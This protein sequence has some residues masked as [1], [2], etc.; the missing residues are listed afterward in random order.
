MEDRG[1]GLKGTACASECPIGDGSDIEG[2]SRSTHGGERIGHF[3]R[4][5]LNRDYVRPSRSSNAAKDEKG[6]EHEKRCGFQGALRSSAP[7]LWHLAPYNEA[8]EL[9]GSRGGETRCA[10]DREETVVAL[11]AR[12]HRVHC[13]R[14]S[15]FCCTVMA[16]P[17]PPP[18]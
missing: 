1:I 11:G 2:A 13:V 12:G 8:G 3:K 18:W 15:R 9:R 14:A 10:C 6:Q 5:V 16:V 7:L 17:P 4:S